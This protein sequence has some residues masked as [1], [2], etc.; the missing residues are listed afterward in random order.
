[1]DVDVSFDTAALTTVDITTDQHDYHCIT[2]E[3]ELDKLCTRLRQCNRFVI[4][5]ETTSTDPL[6]GVLIGLSFSPCDREGYYLP[7]RMK[8]LKPAEEF[9]LFPDGEGSEVQR[10]NHLTDAMDGAMS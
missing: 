6:Q 8:E 7:L 3:K 2:T 10:H 5:T 4:D 1:V 9:G